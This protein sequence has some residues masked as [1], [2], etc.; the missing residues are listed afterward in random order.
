M[1]DSENLPPG[2]DTN[3]ENH[4]EAEQLQKDSGTGG[5]MLGKNGLQMDTGRGSQ[6]HPTAVADQPAAEKGSSDNFQI[7]FG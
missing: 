4:A 3:Q 7:Q 5:E 6:P 1:M 2:N